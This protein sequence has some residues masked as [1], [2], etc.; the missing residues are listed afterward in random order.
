MDI[1][2]YGTINAASFIL[3]AIGFT[4]VYGV[5]RVA[6]FAHGSLYILTGFVVWTLL[7]KAGLNYFFT[8][9][10]SVIITALIGMLVYQLLLIRV[11]GMPASEIIASFAIGMGIIELLKMIGF[12]GSY[13]NPVFVRGSIQLAGTPVDYQRLLVIAFA[14]GSVLYLFVFT[15]FTKAGLA[16]RGIAQDEQ[17]AMMLGINSDWSATVSLAI[18]SA[19]A[20]IAGVVILPLGNI[21]PGIGYEALVYAVAV[22]IVGGLGSLTGTVV[23]GIVLAFAQILT[24][25]F[26]GGEWRMLVIFLGILLILIFKPS[27]LFGR[28]KELEER[29]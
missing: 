23:A 2:I 10:L 26:L 13:G 4:L 5:T 17:A 7:Q 1:L 27:G 11:R 14:L 3:I 19:L 6:N 22:C 29:V 25:R 28:Q 16:L 24:V 9:I 15:H 12:V 18:G 8:I 21:Y 20:S